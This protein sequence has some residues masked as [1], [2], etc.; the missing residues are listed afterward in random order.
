MASFRSPPPPSPESKSKFVLIAATSVDALPCA[1]S[2]SYT[3]EHS[4]VAVV[5]RV[6]VVLVFKESLLHLTPPESTSN[7]PLDVIILSHFHSLSNGTL[8]IRD[9]EAVSPCK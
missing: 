2:T 1:L 5:C 7:D 9:H 4:S 6:R 3:L 8:I